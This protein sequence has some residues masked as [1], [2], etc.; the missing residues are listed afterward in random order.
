MVAVEQKD[1][2]T[3]TLHLHIYFNKIPPTQDS[4][5]S[6]SAARY[7]TKPFEEFNPATQSKVLTFCGD[8]FSK[9]TTSC[10]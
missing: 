4:L 7:K 8:Y 1:E 9:I 2:D 3:Q 10:K 5:C 6:T